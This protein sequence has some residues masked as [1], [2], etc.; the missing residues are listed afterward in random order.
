MAAAV[1]QSAGNRPL[2]KTVPL[3][4]ARWSPRRSARSKTNTTTKAGE[5]AF[6]SSFD[7]LAIDDRQC[8]RQRLEIDH[9][10]WFRLPQPRFLRQTRGRPPD[11]PF[12]IL[13]PDRLHHIYIIGQTGTGKSTLLRNLACQDLRSGIGFCLLDPHGDLA[14]S[15]HEEAAENCLYWD[16]ADPE[17]PFGYNPLTFV[18]EQYRPLVASGLIDTLKKQWADA[19]GVRMEHL[20]RYAVLALL[21]R[22]RSTLRDIMPMFLD[23]PFRREV[24]QSVTDEQVQ[25]FWTVEFPKMNYKTAADGVA[26][27]AN[28]LGAFLAHPVVRKSV[29][30]PER[31][32]RFRKIMDDGKVLIVNLAKGRLGSDIANLLGGLIVSSIALAAYSRQDQDVS[33]RRPF[34]LYADEFQAFTTSAFAEMLS[35]MRKHGLGLILAHQYLSQLDRSITESIF[36]NAGTLIAFRL[37]GGDAAILN[38]QFAQDVPAPCDL[39]HLANHDLFV[40]LMVE[41]QQAAAFTA[42]T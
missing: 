41:G 22:S 7:A 10:E 19:W 3:M 16:A 18:S 35:E 21:S 1:V 17:T 39:V 27:I 28:K 15:V 2:P 23:S 30:D 9:R 13:Q 36:G 12:G 4:P 33:E 26:P 6:V 29:C 20:L 37:G 11:R 14:K 25:Q 8:Q 5:P 32:L 31:S 42:R 40:R 38:R 34:F 24:L